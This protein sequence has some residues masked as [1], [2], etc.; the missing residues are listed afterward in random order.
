MQEV[1]EEAF[2]L[3]APLAHRDWLLWGGELLF[4]DLKEQVEQEEQEK[5]E[6]RL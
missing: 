1:V 2:A 3:F 5:K 6:A 4:L